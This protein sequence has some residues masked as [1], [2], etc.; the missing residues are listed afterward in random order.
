[1]F[2]SGETATF[3]QIAEKVEVLFNTKFERILWSKAQL[4]EALEREPSNIFNKYRMVFTHPGV[5][6]PMEKTFNYQWQ[7]PTIGISEW[8]KANILS[9]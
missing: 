7:I 3:T 1:V 8:A 6:W 5:T 4:S 2:I 9:V